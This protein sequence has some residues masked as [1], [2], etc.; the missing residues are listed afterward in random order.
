MF[1]GIIEE[2][3]CVTSLRRKPSL[4]RYEVE[5][6][7]KFLKGLKK[8]G[9]VSVNGACQ[10]VVEIKK[11]VLTFEAIAETLKI[12]TLNE[13]KVGQKVH[14]ERSLRAEDE[15]G[16][17]LLSGH[18]IGRAKFIKRGGQKHFFKVDLKLVKY[19]FPKGFVA[20]D[21][22][23]LTVCDVDVQRGIFSV[24]LIP[25]TLKRTN[26]GKITLNAKVNF[27]CDSTT[28][29]IVETLERMFIVD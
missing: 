17:H 5:A 25:E 27:E 7:S 9:S 10:T 3:G 13:W 21:G 28:L 29:T 12:T 16:G 20:L 24:S 2:I 14:L 18:V 22:V 6:H 1:T 4:L 26:F 11:N 8:G 19:L 23:S 15:I